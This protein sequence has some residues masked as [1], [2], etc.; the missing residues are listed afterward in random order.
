M[1]VIEQVTLFKDSQTGLSFAAEVGEVTPVSWQPPAELTFEEWAAIGNTLQQVN[2]SL[3]WWIGDWLNYGERKWGEMYAQAVE[4]TG[5]DYDRLRDAKWVSGSIQLSFRNDNLSW[6]H[7]RHVASL[8][9][10][11]QAEWLGRAAA[12]GWRSGQ[13]KEAI[14]ASKQLPV[15]T[16]IPAQPYTNGNSSNGNSSNG[17]GYHTEDTDDVPFASYRPDAGE[18]DGLDCTQEE[19]DRAVEILEG[20]GLQFD[21]ADD[22][23]IVVPPKLSPSP[24]AVH[25]SS[26]TPEHYTPAAIVDAVIDVLGT[27]DLDPCSNSKNTPNVPALYHYTVEDDGLSLP[28]VGKVYMN[29]PYGRAISDW[30]NKLTESLDDGVTEAIALV[31]AR[32]DTQWWN[33]LTA[34]Y[35]LVCFV[36]GRLTFIGNEDAAPFPSAVVYLSTS[37]EGATRFYDVF[38]QFGR[39]WQEL[40]REW[41]AE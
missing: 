4:V 5:W 16:P 22:R 39:I 29:P 24:M 1:T 9:P 2:A 28:W 19:I 27:I 13:L 18:S 20:T 10:T 37:S 6:T 15:I 3:N 40:P 7:H 34:R 26:D 31:P 33:A 30:V 23:L 25:F 11:E 14:K 41:L 36:S 17:N 38:S 12:N 32:V 8:S 21:V 35:C